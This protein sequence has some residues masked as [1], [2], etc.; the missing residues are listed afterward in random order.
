MVDIHVD[1]CRAPSMYLQEPIQRRHAARSL[2]I[3]DE[4][5]LRGYH[6]LPSVRGELLRRLGRLAEAAPELERAAELTRNNR[7]R[8]LLLGR[9]RGCRAG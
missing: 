3:A 1:F 5:A 4:P 8:E 7:K 9:A 6:L 2:A